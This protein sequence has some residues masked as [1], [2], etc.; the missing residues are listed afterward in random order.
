MSKLI[1]NT[2]RYG[3][4]ENVLLLGQPNIILSKRI[5]WRF[6]W[7]TLKDI[8]S[9]AGNPSLASIANMWDWGMSQLLAIKQE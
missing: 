4:I 6:S 9:Q 3:V 5:E 7:D 1:F 2:K 8:D